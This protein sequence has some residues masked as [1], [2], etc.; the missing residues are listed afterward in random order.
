MAN[1]PPIKTVEYKITGNKRYYKVVYSD[2]EYSEFEFSSDINKV[3]VLSYF[4]DGENIL[5]T[6]NAI[7][8][9]ASRRTNE[10]LLSFVQANEPAAN[11][12]KIKEVIYNLPLYTLI[13]VTSTGTY[14]TVVEDKGGELLKNEF[15]KV[16]DVTCFTLSPSQAQTSDQVNAIDSY[17][18]SNYPIS[19]YNLQLVQISVK[20]TKT[21]YR[22]VYSNAKLLQ[23]EIYLD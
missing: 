8:Q 1:I 20:P 18:K 10:T 2:K 6:L 7:K 22:L 15:I 5:V 23:I 3:N 19:E 11:P 13:L 9:L 17:L 4:I 21:S 12:A 14:S 16:S